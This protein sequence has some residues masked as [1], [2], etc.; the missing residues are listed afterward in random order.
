MVGLCYQPEPEELFLV[1]LVK[2]SEGGAKVGLLAS[3]N[4]TASGSP[5][6]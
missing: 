3:A 5:H 6:G 4:R 1:V 2:L